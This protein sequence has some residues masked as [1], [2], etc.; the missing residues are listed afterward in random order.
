MRK[1]LSIIWLITLTCSVSA[2][3]LKTHTGKVNVRGVL[4]RSNFENCTE[5]YTYS[6]D[7]YE[8]EI[9]N[10]S[11]SLTGNY[12]FTSEGWDSGV[13]MTSNTKHGLSVTAKYKDDKYNGV[14][15]YK[16][17]YTD[18]V[19][20]KTYKSAVAEY[21]CNYIDGVATVPYKSKLTREG[22]VVF[23]YERTA[24]TFKFNSGNTT[25]TGQ[26][27]ANGKATGRWV[28]NGD[29]YE[30][31]NGYCVSYVSFNGKNVS[32]ETNP[33]DK[34]IA[35]DFATGRITFDELIKQDYLI[36]NN[37]SDGCKQ[38]C[39]KAFTVPGF[40]NKGGKIDY[41][42]S[43][44]WNEGV[45][46]KS[47]TKDILSYIK[48]LA[49]TYEG[50]K[51]D[52]IYG[53]SYGSRIGALSGISGVSDLLQER[54]NNNVG[55]L[56]NRWVTV[57]GGNDTYLPSSLWTFAI[58]YFPKE[59]FNETIVQPA[60]KAEPDIVAG[61]EQA[62][63]DA[64]LAD[65]VFVA[66]REKAEANLVGYLNTMVLLSKEEAKM[67]IDAKKYMR[68]NV[69]SYDGNFA[70][71]GFNSKAMD[72]YTPC[73][74]M[75]KSKFA[76]FLP[77]N[78]MRDGHPKVFKEIFDILPV[79]GV[80]LIGVCYEV[81]FS[82]YALAYLQLDRSDEGKEPLIVEAVISWDDGGVCFPNWGQGKIEGIVEMKEV[83][84]EQN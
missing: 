14:F 66:W 24:T 11:Y 8:H 73:E 82:P 61:A 26:Y 53:D 74:E 35:T 83:V 60:L 56:N 7:K 6:L 51:T 55:P 5:T 10:G 15:S 45:I 46:M 54:L 16:E 32:F 30:M 75:I 76:Q 27:D 59:W 71:M 9:L 38:Y 40:F 20:G 62:K 33:S 52:Y 2:Q 79:Q 57:Y 22:K 13:A 19:N 58:L 49:F 50:G 80:K 81:D 70:N 77:E 37:G 34:K 39:D 69:R 28:V 43:G 67:I 1:L 21:S 4:E 36:G 41:L 64:R 3:N 63:A 72:A 17:T 84:L 44:D 65:P 48:N 25:V 31:V 18:V 78:S 23:E 29:W 47:A 42:G 68:Q 12:S